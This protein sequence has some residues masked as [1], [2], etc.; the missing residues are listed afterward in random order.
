MARAADEEEKEEEKEAG[1]G[2]VE[3]EGYRKKRTEWWRG[4]QTEMDPR[5]FHTTTMMQC[6]RVRGSIRHCCF[7]P[8][9]SSPGRSGRG[10]SKW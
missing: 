2:G 3:A 4:I 1:R 6:E 8:A 10:G 9:Y 5:R 7:G